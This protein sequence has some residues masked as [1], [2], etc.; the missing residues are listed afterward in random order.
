[1]ENWK[2]E[3]KTDKAREAFY[4]HCQMTATDD[5]AFKTNCRNTVYNLMV[6]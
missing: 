3:R 1:M 4:W 5:T 6:K 2:L